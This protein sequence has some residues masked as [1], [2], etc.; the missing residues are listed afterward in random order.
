MKLFL[1]R[2]FL[3]ILPVLL[4]AYFIDLV[5]SKSLRN[6]H[7]YAND[8]YSV[9]NDIYNSNI[10]ARLLILGASNAWVEVDPTILHKK[11][12]TSVYNLG[13]D[14][15]NFWLEHF[16][17]QEALKYNIKPD[18]VIQVLGVNTLDKRKDLYNM[19]QF[20]P[21]M[22]FNQE[23]EKATSSYLGFEKLD[24]YLPLI[25][26]Y[27][28]KEAIIYSI[29]TS[30]DFKSNKLK[31]IKGYYGQNLRWNND[32][33]F[34]KNKSN[35]IKVN[36]DSLTKKSFFKFIEECKLNDIKLIFILPP[37]YY[38]G[39]KFIS[40]FNEIINLYVKIANVNQIPFLDYSKDSISFKKKY[41]YN[42]THL[43]IDGANLFSTRIADQIDSIRSKK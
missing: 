22:L 24:F 32:F 27:G 8:E 6:V 23:I 29:L 13:I 4:A 42:A 37:T 18:L 41:F 20:L 33:E 19:D 28:K 25:R 31:R 16:R 36:I 11:L 38:E 14:G 26:Y 9:W 43:N 12:Q 5:L 35:S 1:K 3:F 2:L 21:Y 10:N 30:L 34:A 7:D 40:N 15:H 17:F 39:Q